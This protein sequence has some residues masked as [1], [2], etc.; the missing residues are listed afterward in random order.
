MP[1]KE[2]HTWIAWMKEK[3][4]ALA[5]YTT[6]CNRVFLL[7]GSKECW[8]RAYVCARGRYQRELLLG[9]RRW[10]GTDGKKTIR[11]GGK[12][13]DGSSLR[14]KS[15]KAFIL[16][17]A[18]AGLI[19]EAADGYKKTLAI[20]CKKV[21]FALPKRANDA[22]SY[23]MRHPTYEALGRCIGWMVY[24]YEVSEVQSTKRFV[25]EPAWIF[26]GEARKVALKK[27]QKRAWK[28]KR[29]SM[30]LGHQ[31]PVVG[32]KQ[33]TEVAIERRVYSVAETQDIHC[34]DFPFGSDA[35]A[36]THTDSELW[37]Q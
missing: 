7:I 36:E 16:R 18:S 6:M 9:F 32:E 26:E 2:W 3:R 29:K 31:A 1:A 19:W 28:Q 30:Q 34:E 21:P 20:G 33:T 37:I 8:L 4:Q 35:V 11:S 12:D 27:A 5:N 14:R 25:P 23:L 10:D 15:I 22:V 24:A 13:L 17:L